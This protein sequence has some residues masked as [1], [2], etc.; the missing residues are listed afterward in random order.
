ML[1]PLSYEGLA[2]SL[3]RMPGESWSVRLG[4]AASLL[5][6]CAAPVR[7]PWT[8]LSPPPRHAALI[9]RRWCR[10]KSRGH[11]APGSNVVAVGRAMLVGSIGMRTG[12]AASG[13]DR[14]NETR[15]LPT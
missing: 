6:V 10:A 2:C 5:T 9:V 12:R 3:P 1:Y 7:A 4:L 8:S 14:N 11:G 13:K 15:L